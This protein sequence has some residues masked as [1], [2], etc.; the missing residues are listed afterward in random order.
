MLKNVLI[1]FVLEMG[2]RLSSTLENSGQTVS[3][4]LQNNPY[5][6]SKLY[7][8]F[9]VTK[10]EINFLVPTLNKKIA[11]RMNPQVIFYKE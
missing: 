6:P 2:Q 8:F 11:L 10:T 5:M 3:P 7:G 4:K 1:I 9:P